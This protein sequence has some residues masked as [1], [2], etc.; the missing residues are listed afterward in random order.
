VTPV[1][2]LLPVLLAVATAVAPPALAQDR[3]VTRH[4]VLISL[5]GMRPDAI[6][7]FGASTLQRLMREGAHAARARTIPLSHTLPS[8]ASMLTGVGSDR[9]GITWNDER[10]E[11]EG[12]VRVPTVFDLADDAGLETAAF[13][14]KAKLRHLFRPDA[15]RH[16]VAPTRWRDYWM[17]TEVVDRL[18]TYL[19]HRRPALLFV[20]VSEPDYAGH[21]GG[22]MSWLYGLAV[23]RSDAAV[24][25]V[26]RLAEDAFG[27]DNFTVIVTADHGGSGHDHGTAA[28][29]D[30]RIPWIAWGKGVRTGTNRDEVH[31][32]DTAATVLWLLGVAVPGDWA[33]RPVRQA[34]RSAPGRGLQADQVQD[35]RVH[36]LRAAGPDPGQDPHP[37]ERRQ[38]PYRR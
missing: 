3:A 23:H 22:W 30:M 35:R 15:P 20:H 11:A 33:G 32:T 2:T 27:A 7:H 31:I 17:A 34:F 21:V 1:R 10:L 38:L 16:V 6:D 26:L 13:A 29:E 14:G 18:A 4:V 19:T 12:R 5:D 9:H 24:A 28:P 8:H 37:L 25:A 36:Q